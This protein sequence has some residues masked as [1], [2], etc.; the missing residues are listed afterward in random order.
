MCEACCCCYENGYD[1]GVH[2]YDDSCDDDA[3]GD[4][5]DFDFDEIEVDF[6]GF[7]SGQGSCVCP[8]FDHNNYH[9]RD[10]DCDYERYAASNYDDYNGDGAYLYAAAPVFHLNYKPPSWNLIWLDLLSSHFRFP[11]LILNPL[12]LLPNLL[13]ESSST[14]LVPHL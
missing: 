10:H 2:D 1:D 4:D 3:D 5:G 14:Q 7:Y 6:S 8:C 11:Y 12:C 13:F 9:D